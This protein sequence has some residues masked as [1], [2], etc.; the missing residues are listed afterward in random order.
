MF[1]SQHFRWLRAATLSGVMALGLWASHPASAQYKTGFEPNDADGNYNGS[2]A[3]TDVV[4][5]NGWFKP[6]ITSLDEAI[7]TYAGNALGLPANPTGGTQFLGG[8]NTGAFARAQQN[9]N[10]STQNAWTVS[11][12]MA[13]AHFGTKP[14]FSNLSSVS[15]QPSGN[16]N[17]YISIVDAWDHANVADTYSLYYFA[18]GDWVNHDANGTNQNLTAINPVTVAGKLANW[19]GLAVNH[20]YRV[21][22]SFDFTSNAVTSV[23]ITD[24]TTSTTAT[25]RTAG[26]FLQGGAAPGAGFTKPTA[27]RCFVGGNDPAT[28]NQ[29]PGNIAGWDNFDIEPATAASDLITISGKVT[30]TSDPNVKGEFVYIE[31]RPTDGS[32]AVQGFTFL[33]A[34]GSY[35]LGATPKGKYNLWCKAFNTLAT[36]V[37]NVDASAG[38]VSG[39][40]VTLIPGDVNGDN[41]INIT[42]LGML[43]DAFGTTSTSAKY[44]LAADLN[45]DGKVDIVDLGILADGFGKNGA[46]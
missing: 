2:A 11:Y 9:F 26:W 4:G 25:A 14:P 44:N 21:S 10:F 6:V 46:P 42:D 8:K 23:S 17:R 39:V 16:A 38:N 20:W 37:A 33:Q 31:L 43:A 12:D 30:I 19:A 13:G 27:F 18:N 5:Q 3:G 1:V 45:N 41:K 40:N 29:A 34:D 32:D 22:T 36:V 24:L 15:L 28:G 7:F 35:N